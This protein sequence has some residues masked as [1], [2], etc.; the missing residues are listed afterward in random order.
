MLYEFRLPEA[1]STEVAMLGW[2]VREG[3]RVAADQV[4]CRV[5]AGKAEVEIRCPQ[6]GVLLKQVARIGDQV[7]LRQ[8]V[9]I[10][11]PEAQSLQTHGLALPSVRKL[12][13]ELK[14]DLSAVKGGGPGGR[15]TEEDVRE[16]QKSLPELPVLKRPEEQAPA[17]QPAPA[18]EIPPER[19]LTLDDPALALPPEQPTAPLPTASTA[20]PAPPRP[21]EIV[22]E[23]PTP[24][25]AIPAAALT[26]IG[27]PETTPPPTHP[28][29]TPPDEERIAFM[30]PRKR[31]AER[32][33]HSWKSIPHAYGLAEADVTALRN[34]MR[35]LQPE[36]HKKGCDLSELA[37]VVRALAKTLHECP[38][39]NS[40]MT[41]DGHGI[42]FKRSCNIGIAMTVGHAPIVPVLR[43]AQKKDLWTLASELSKL[44]ARARD[45]NIPEAELHGA[46]FT[47]TSVSSA[48]SNLVLPVILQPE[49]ASLGVTKAHE[50]AVVIGGGIHSRWRMNL[51][52]S[53]DRRCHDPSH[54]AAFLSAL[55]RRLEAPRS[56]A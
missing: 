8:L 11:R 13:S 17:P 33:A 51:G 47:V 1:G 44:P 38:D 39:F 23:K 55:A 36:A 18:P 40:H 2:E 28:E 29:A 19:S 35:E 10:L 52:L 24:G 15:I 5:L 6:A 54:A 32:L 25:L 14:V 56:L 12:A 41:E 42:V 49:T 48:A 22:E 21:A 37:F 45:H 53:Y 3:D 7:R 26:A 43:D 31:A 46:T 27:V 20:P 34:L 4:V 16:A 50:R 30:G 9:A